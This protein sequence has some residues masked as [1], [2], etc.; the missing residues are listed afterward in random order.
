MII[1]FSISVTTYY[2]VKWKK[3]SIAIQAPSTWVILKFQSNTLGPKS[4][5]SSIVCFVSTAIQTLCQSSSTS[6]CKTIAVDTSKQA[7]LNQATITR[8]YAK[9]LKFRPIGS[10]INSKL[11]LSEPCKDDMDGFGKGFCISIVHSG[12]NS[13]LSNNV[14]LENY[15]TSLKGL[16]TIWVP[17]FSFFG[18]NLLTKKTLSVYKLYF[19]IPLINRHDWIL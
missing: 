10:Y 7:S 13:C 8:K 6:S 12:V 18:S 9:K 5:S 17:I 3:P 4:L 15:Q 1:L 19:I 11:K 2:Q 14:I 16:L